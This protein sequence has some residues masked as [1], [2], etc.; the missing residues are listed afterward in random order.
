MAKDPLVGR[1]PLVENHWPEESGT[2]RQVFDAKLLRLQ[3]TQV[4]QVVFFFRNSFWFYWVMPK[5]LWTYFNKWGIDVI[6][7]FSVDSPKSHAVVVIY[8]KNEY[9]QFLHWRVLDFECIS[10]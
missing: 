7:I 5:I 4:L 9:S 8:F 10:E 2:Y 1:D 3:W 6:V